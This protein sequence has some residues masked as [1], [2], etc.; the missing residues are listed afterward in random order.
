M[1]LKTLTLRGFKSFASATTL[2]FEPGIT[3]VVGPNGSG[4][5]NV[6]DALAWVM[7]EQGAKSLRGGAMAD[8][9]FA[10]TSKRP[11]LGRAEV[12]LTIDNSDGVLPI[13]YSE[14]TISRTL[15]S[16]GASEYAIN[17]TPCRLLDIQDLLSDTGMGREMHVIVGQGR[18]DSV[19]QAGPEE[20]RHFIEEAA[21]I[22]KH[23][24]RK[25]R[26]LRKLDT[27]S[28]NL[29]RVSDLSAEIRRQ[30]GPLAKQADVARRAQVV[31]VDLRDA[32]ARLLADD[33]VQLSSALAA[34]IADETALRTEREQVE[35]AQQDR[36]RRLAHL[37]AE[38]A[39]AAPRLSET[40]ETWYRL[41]GLRERLRGTATLAAE[42]TRLLGS[43]A[44][45]QEGQ[46]PD[47]LEAQAQR[48]R[49][50][51]AELTAEREQAQQGLAD[52]QAAR[53]EAEEAAATAERELAGVH[54]GVAD[55]REG[56]AR[57]TGQVGARRSRLEGIES[58][59]ARLREDLRSAEARQ[60]EARSGYVELEQTVVGAQEGE[61][62]LDAAHEA[63]LETQ[64]AAQAKVVE[65]TEAEREAESARSTWAARRDALDLSMDRKDGT[66][67]LLG[68][69][70]PAGLL[71]SLADLITVASGYEN[72][73]A[74][75]LGPLADAAAVES[76]AAG[77][78]A[79][80]LVRSNDSGQARLVVAGGPGDGEPAVAAA[81]AGKWANDLVS[82]DET[83]GPTIA[84]LLAGVVVVED[85][86]QARRVVGAHDVMAVTLDGDVVARTQ[87]R[88]GS[89]G[90]PSVLE[91]HAA[92][93]E[94]EQNLQ[95]AVG[96]A[97]QV[98]FALGPAREEVQTAQE[99]VDAT[100][101]DLHES[102]AQLAAVAEKLGQFQAA[103]RA[104]G[105]EA[106]R[107]RPAIE[108][109]EL[110][111]EQVGAELAE[112]AERLERAQAEPEEQATDLE[113]ATAQRDR[114][115]EAATQ[116]RGLETEARLALRTVEER[117]RAVTARAESLEGAAAAER[118]AREVARER[119][120]RRAVQA[121]IA[122][123]VHAAAETALQ[124]LE[125]SLSLAA[126]RREQ[127]EAAREERE[128]ALR[129][130]REELEQLS[131]RHSELT[132]VVHRDEVARAQ[133]KLRIEQLEQ[134]AVEEL[135]LDPQVLAS[136]YGPDQLVPP[137]PAPGTAAADGE[138][139]DAEE[140][141]PYVRAEQEK[142]YKAAQRAL[143]LLGK[144]NPLALEEH[145]ALEERHQF[146]A[147]QLADLKKSKADLMQ[148]VAQIDERVE[149]VF[150]AAYHDT[151]VQFEQ[152]FARLFPG[153]KGAL[154]LT[155]PDDMLTTGIEVQAQPPGKKINR[156]SLL[157]GG[158]RSLT[159][160]AL[161][162]AI[163]K[164]RP[165]PFYV[166]DEVEAALDDVNLGRLLEIFTELR[167]DSQ[168]IVVT[169]Q[170]RTM[171][172]G[173]A[174]YGVTM[175][176]DG[177]TQVISQRLREEQ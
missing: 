52:A 150:T 176:G 58:E 41:S 87:I 27:M 55:R 9:I 80:R 96:R 53:K 49:E 29:A 45:P 101:A 81:P 131:A 40:T 159:A 48:T 152:V 79:V 28:A 162:I 102:D 138:H 136:E 168:L 44:A 141:R 132:D 17:N 34:E 148:I 70:G 18:L 16:G 10:G 160:V 107:I 137:V 88:G 156:L 67:T 127:A 38:A 124:H 60:E 117:V 139:A 172:V 35:Q 50:A 163:F 47:D 98:R 145:A 99:R 111:K 171:E 154:V 116:A 63:A 134:R 77:V 46:D 146:L 5:S 30:L 24:K 12:S 130:V 69:D 94:A 126:E 2:H 115:A 174:L 108:T 21:G 91:L 113:G 78:D 170:K 7:G 161:L 72:A 66:G 31:Q 82:A 157:S 140:P 32:R 37:E 155:D 33:L 56:L 36:R 133:Q 109:A 4:K 1:H 158:E 51:E 68:A 97:E 151:A 100:L 61:V 143:S 14:V 8:V 74:A 121:A 104:A 110:T 71:G 90:G 26:A 15:F 25:E 118:H 142:R 175:R 120:R 54:R 122:T 39:A 76:V 6:V 173:D 169:H 84:R 83:L 106:D 123:E 75:A 166:M 128:Q 20:R 95:E 65:L 19:L 43:A 114:T 165:S 85:L 86:A 144:V 92:R 89:P 59:L 3:C 93:D 64:E 125:H 105:A 103:M 42:R 73:I 153:G 11:P 23:R 135:G 22:L 57:L 13:E 149:H 164:A 177:V 147:E 112:L 119:A 167:Q 129:A 62:G